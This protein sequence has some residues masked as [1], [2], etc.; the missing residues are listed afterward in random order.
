M[1][2]G[3]P[4]NLLAHLWDLSTGAIAVV[5]LD[6]TD[7]TT[8][9]VSHL[10]GV[11]CVATSSQITAWAIHKEKDNPGSIK[12][13]VA[14]GCAFANGVIAGFGGATYAGPLQTYLVELSRDGGGTFCAACWLEDCTITL[15]GTSQ[16]ILIE[17]ESTFAGY[18][19]TYVDHVTF[20]GSAL[21]AVLGGTAG[22]I[23]L[24]PLPGNVTYASSTGTTVHGHYYPVALAGLLGLDQSV[25]LRP[26]QRSIANLPHMQ[27]RFTATVNTTAIYPTTPVNVDIWDDTVA[28][29]LI[30]VLRAVAGKYDPRDTVPLGSRG[31]YHVD[32]VGRQAKAGAVGTVPKLAL[33]ANPGTGVY[34]VD[35][36]TTAVFDA[37][38]LAIH[39]GNEQ[40]RAQAQFL[41]DASNHGLPDNYRLT[42]LEILFPT[43]PNAAW[44]RNLLF[45]AVSTGSESGGVYYYVHDGLFRPCS[46]TMDVACM[47]LDGSAPQTLYVGGTYGVF[48]WAPV[49]VQ[50]N[51]PQPKPSPGVS[52]PGAWAQLGA[53]SSAVTVLCIP[54]KDGDGNTVVWA[55]AALGTSGTGIFQYPAN[56][57]ED[58]S[59]LGY[60][61]WSLL[62]QGGNITA[63]AGGIGNL[64]YV[65]GSDPTTVYYQ[66]AGQAAVR[67]DEG[68]FAGAGITGLDYLPG[69]VGIVVRTT[70]GSAGLY[71][72]ALG[73]HTAIDLN[74]DGSLSDAYGNVLVNAV[75]ETSAGSL[76]GSQVALLAGTDT[77]I[78]WTG[79][80][81]GVG[82]LGWQQATAQ[83]G[84]GDLNVTLLAAGATQAILDR[85]FER[86]YAGNDTAL[87]I[88]NTGALWFFDALNAA[89]DIG[90][91]WMAL[92][93][94]NGLANFV[95]NNFDLLFASGTNLTLAKTNAGRG[96]STQYITIAATDL[97]CPPQNF[98][99]ARKL[100]ARNDF[101]YRLVK[102]DSPAPYFA[103][104]IQEL[105]EITANDAVSVMQ[106]SEQLALAHLRY[107]MEAAQAPMTLDLSGMAYNVQDAALATLDTGDQIA[108]TCQY[109]PAGADGTITP[110]CN[111]SSAPFYVLVYDEILD[112]GLMKVTMSVGSIMALVD[113]VLT[114]LR[115]IVAGTSWGLSRDKRYR[116][117][118]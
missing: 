11:P 104:E 87:W 58:N 54:G 63:M 113:D 93:S 50:L 12:L 80:A 22:T 43:A 65:D 66:A 92:A 95:D 112:A 38:K 15:G 4:L 49:P 9:M 48:S 8:H 111:W 39:P 62:A 5:N 99:W 13:G 110:V 20:D 74:A 52:A 102:V 108:L 25:P 117:I 1:S 42:G 21:S 101:N 107:L 60:G 33:V 2:R 51:T 115:E 86:V 55:L 90:P 47:A 88:S 23:P 94:R 77:G 96:V 67:L 69:M 100:T 36:T 81:P 10:T 7:L 30:T 44:Y 78:F 70:A 106:A 98:V 28:N 27:Y 89:L 40:L 109:S 84:I 85:S 46:Q 103:M 116:R 118:R 35:Q 68:Q 24:P 32:M 71:F 82:N 34:E 56:A 79:V 76:N 16:G 14:F 57:G 19:R 31:H 73:D 6:R 17:A 64:Y 91:F 114:T 41:G 18:G 72:I 37:T 75:R 3:T 61:G 53:L 97:A 45:V 105:A 59:D 26:D 29:A 83:S